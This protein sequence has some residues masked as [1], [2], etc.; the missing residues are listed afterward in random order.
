ME[1]SRQVE[2]ANLLS[3]ATVSIYLMEE[4]D[5]SIYK[6]TKGTEIVLSINDIIYVEIKGLPKIFKTDHLLQT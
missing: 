5:L 6:P 1:V 2:A 3:E 4:P